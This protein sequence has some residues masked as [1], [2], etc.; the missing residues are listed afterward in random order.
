MKIVEG[1]HNPKV[2]GSNPAPA[3]KQDRSLALREVG[4]VFSCRT[5]LGTIVFL[6]DARHLR[7][8]ARLMG[9]ISR[10]LSCAGG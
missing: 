6:D 10:Q 4:F 9:Q 8:V 5:H 7:P 2:A 1:K 3:T